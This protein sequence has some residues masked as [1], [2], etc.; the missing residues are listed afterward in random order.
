[1]K[2]SIK[3][4]I[5]NGLVCGAIL[6]I[7]LLSKSYIANHLKLFQSHVVIPGFFS[8]TYIQ[9]RGAAWSILEGQTLFLIGIALIAGLAMIYYFIKSRPEQKLLRF[10]LAMVFAGM[11]GNLIDRVMLGYVR[12]FFDF[13]IFGYNFPVFNVADMGV[14]IGMAIIILQI[15]MEEYA[16]WKYKK[17][18]SKK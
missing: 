18:M 2:R 5:L 10:G 16:Q 14:T 6:V 9:N 7:D 15:L 11:L 1:M 4:I 13:I 17:S 12:D 8:I 3:Q